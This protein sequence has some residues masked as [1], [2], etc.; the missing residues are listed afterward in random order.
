MV[1]LWGRAPGAQLANVEVLGAMLASE[2]R[3][4]KHT[5]TT[6]NAPQLP[7]CVKSS[8]GCLASAHYV[9][10]ASVFGGVLEGVEGWRGMAPHV[11]GLG[12]G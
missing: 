12:L 6:C 11:D 10:G 7:R 4:S 2:L 5:A 3:G 8:M 1:P 9:W